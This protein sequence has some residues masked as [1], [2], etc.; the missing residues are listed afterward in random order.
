M[1][2]HMSAVNNFLRQ[3]DL[4]GNAARYAKSWVGARQMGFP[5]V[6]MPEDVPDDVTIALAKQDSVRIDCDED[7]VSF[8]LRMPKLRTENRRGASSPFALFT[9]RRSTASS[10]NCTVMERRIAGTPGEQ[11]TWPCE[12]SLSK[13]SPRIDRFP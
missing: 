7:R 8:T 9:H 5:Q 10:A 1:Q 12:R 13:S 2:V 6:K 3:M 11:V 4:D